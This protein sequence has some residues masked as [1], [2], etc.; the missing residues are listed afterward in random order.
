MF[1]RDGATVL[2]GEI[3]SASA[4]A[5]AQVAARNKKLFMVSGRAPTRCGARTATGTPSTLTSRIP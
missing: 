2:M 5:I 3:S 4:L 1:E